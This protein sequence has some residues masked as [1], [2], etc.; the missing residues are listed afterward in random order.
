MVA[1]K[2]MLVDKDLI[3]SLVR[4][5]YDI[6]TLRI[7]MGNR[8]AG[9]FR[10]R[11]GVKPGQSE[12]EA[13]EEGVD[14]SVLK[15]LREEYKKIMDG[16]KVFPRA[17]T[18]KGTPLINNY[19]ELSL[20]AQYMELEK[21]E[22]AHFRRLETALNGNVPIWDEFMINVT[23]LGHT[24]AGIIVSEINIVEAKYPSSLWQYA[25]LGVE[26][27]GKGTSKKLIH[28]HDIRYKKAC[29]RTLAKKEQDL[30]D[31]YLKKNKE[32]T[33]EEI[34]KI[35]LLMTWAKWSDDKVVTAEEKESI[36]HLIETL[37]KDL[38]LGVRR[39][40]QYNPFLK[41][42]LMGVLAGSFIRM[43]LVNR[44]VAKK[45]KDG[46]VVMKNGEPIMVAEK[47]ANGD[48]IPI[49]DQCS[50][51]V[52]IYLDYK[53]RIK[54]MPAHKD[55]SKGHRHQMSLRYMIKRFLVDLYV[56]WRTLEG[57][58]V[59]TEYSEGKLGMK[60]GQGAS[61][62]RSTTPDVVALDRPE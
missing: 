56:A 1:P 52:K 19:T 61:D 15:V 62:S 4:G 45:D 38:P 57:L 47:D 33:E 16:V 41:T 26:R 32:L 18:F 30:V 13:E 53:N 58:P 17:A 8:I 2:Y 43:G 55:K 21:S 20:L 6:Q 42:K 7:Q 40:I 3:K 28:L 29:D 14:V 35:E 54:N 31:F 34:P 46:N 48:S 51:Y 60:H 59:A 9:N 24:I 37:P 25:G 11:V 39:G 12:E 23:G 22:E 10:S 36:K 27:D 5:A 44:K 50:K 49:Y